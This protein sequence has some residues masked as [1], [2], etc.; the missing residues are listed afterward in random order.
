M[1]IMSGR[2]DA[3]FR[4]ISEQHSVRGRDEELDLAV[5]EIPVP[6]V[7]ELGK[8]FSTWNAWPPPRL[9]P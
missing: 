2:D 1:L 8:R 6:L 5:L 4:N 9:S 3:P 7:Y